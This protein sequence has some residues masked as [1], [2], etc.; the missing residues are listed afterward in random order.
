MACRRYPGNDPLVSIARSVSGAPGGTAVVPVSIAGPA[1]VKAIDL[2]FTYDT[3]RLQLT[4]SDVKLA[5]LT[6]K[7]WAL[8]ANVK[9]GVAYVA[10]YS[11]TPLPASLVAS[12]FLDLD[13]QVLAKAPAGAAKI[14]L[15]ASKGG[16]LN[17][18][19][20]PMTVASGSV[21]VAQP[22]KTNTSA[23]AIDAVL[24]QTSGSAAASAASALESWLDAIKKSQSQQTVNSI[25]AVM[26]AY[27]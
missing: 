21:V 18:G 25:D 16:G 23:A 1:G 17:E 5:G 12:N 14:A 19:Q 20:M 10:A 6:A 15:S 3:S 7:G 2:T 22:V 26:A 4:D 13:F 24:A 11:T 9:N 27:A 8:T